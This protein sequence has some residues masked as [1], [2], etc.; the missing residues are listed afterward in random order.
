MD[1]GEIVNCFKVNLENEKKLAAR[2]IINGVLIFKSEIE[3]A[4]ECTNIPSY[5]LS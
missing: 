2:N 5:L 4:T 3:R 1:I